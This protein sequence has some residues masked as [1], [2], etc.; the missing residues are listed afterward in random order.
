[1][2]VTEGFSFHRASGT[3][4]RCLVG[5]WAAISSE[6]WTWNRAA[7]RPGIL[8]VCYEDPIPPRVRYGEED[9]PGERAPPVGEVA[10]PVAANGPAR[11]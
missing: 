9:V 5:D 1:M 2:A 6:K 11:G 7:A 8:G 3:D 10:R 4:G